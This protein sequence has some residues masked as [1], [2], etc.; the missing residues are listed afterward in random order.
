M[1]SDTRQSLQSGIL[2]NV[3]GVDDLSTDDS[4]DTFLKKVVTDKYLE[5]YNHFER[6]IAKLEQKK[7]L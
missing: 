2:S 4:K 6:K 5:K 7:E 1:L 3:M